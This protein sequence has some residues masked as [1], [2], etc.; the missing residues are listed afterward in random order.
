MTVFIA[1]SVDGKLSLGSEGNKTRFSEDI[2][3]HTG[4]IYRIERLESQRTL[5]QNN[6]YWFYLSLI[7]RETGNAAV[8]LH[9]FFKRKF[10]LPKHI[11]VMGN[12][13][14]IPGTTTGLK[15]H[16]FSEY[17][18]KICALTNVP[19]PNPEESGYISNY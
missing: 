12:D 7:E 19:L 14:R 5:S 11:S 16:E 4:A 18:D 2:K 3:D 9:E 6:Y 8:E 17:L 15:K 13:I 10:L 1:K